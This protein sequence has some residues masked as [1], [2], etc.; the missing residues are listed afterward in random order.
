MQYQRL[1]PI[2]VSLAVAV[3]AC[4]GRAPRTWT[5]RAYQLAISSEPES[6]S[7]P[8]RS[9]TRASWLRIPGGSAFFIIDTVVARTEKRGV[10]LL[11]ARTDSGVF[12]WAGPD[13]ADT[14]VLYSDTGTRRTATW[15]ARFTS[16]D[17]LL[18]HISTGETRL[19][20]YRGTVGTA[21][22]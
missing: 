12:G 5:G 13:G 7:V 20:R 15:R 8:L 17:L 1:V 19:Y 22:R 14:L 10:T 2:G 4:V 21:S 6:R 11:R 18:Q 3:A 9:G 16:G